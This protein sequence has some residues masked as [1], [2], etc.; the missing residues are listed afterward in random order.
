[1][2]LANRRTIELDM[3]TAELLEARA[4][5]RGLSVGA[6]LAEFLSAEEVGPAAWPALRGTRAS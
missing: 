3:A 5:A 2:K 4:K 6:L 1:V